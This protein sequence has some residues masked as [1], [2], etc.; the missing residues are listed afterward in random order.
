VLLREADPA[1]AVQLAGRLQSALREPFLVDGE[2]AFVTASAGIAAVSPGMPADE[3]LRDAN[4]A[5]RR[6]RE[7]GVG[8][9]EVF[10]AAMREH[11]RDQMRLQNDLRLA[12]ARAEFEVHYQPKVNL[13]NHA[14]EGFEALVRWNRPGFGMVPPDTFIGVAEQTGLIVPLGRYVLDRACTD[15]ADLRRTYPGVWVSVNVSGRQLAEADL[16]EQ[17]RECLERAA[18]SASALRLEVTETFLVADPEKALSILTRL[19]SMGVGLKLDDF[20]SGYSSLDYLQ[21]F[22]FDTIKID[23]SFVARL[24]SSHESA[25]I[26]RAIAGLSRSLNMSVVAEGI[27]NREQLE[28][29]KEMGCQLGQ[30][31]LFSKPLD[32]ARLKEFLTRWPKSDGSATPILELAGRQAGG[33]RLEPQ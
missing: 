22:P 24:T 17:V 26:V 20:G 12:L 19:R 29:L 13:E 27:E 23:R 32:L 3:P 14:V 25:A 4:A 30:G 33:E 15:I 2:T 16:A 9:S 21:R 10:R 7:Q 28:K 1:A 5:M 31:Y 6:A 18:L 11:E 8:R